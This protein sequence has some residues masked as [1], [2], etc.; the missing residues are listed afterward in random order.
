MNDAGKDLGKDL[1]SVRKHTMHDS[2][3]P[4]ELP[5]I[6]GY[7]FNSGVDFG[8]IVDSFATT[9]YQASELAKAIS[10]INAMRKD[11]C[12][13][14]LGYTS[15]MVSSGLREVFCYLAKH[16][17]VD[18][19]VTTAGGIEE[20]FIKCLGPFLLGE[21]NLPGKELREAGI[22]R[23]GNI[24]VPNSRYLAFEDF[25]IPVLEHL[26]EEQQKTG[27]V[28]T[29]SQFTACLG[30]EIRD[31][32]SIYFWAQ[33]NRIPVFCPA[34]TDGSIGD[35][36]YFFSFKHPGFKIDI[37]GDLKGLNDL[38]LEAKKT[39]LIILGAGVVKHHILNANM[40]RNGAD[41]AVYINTS[42]EFDGS[43][44]GAKP[45]E[46]VSWGKLLPEEGNENP[47]PTIQN[48]SYPSKTQIQ[49]SPKPPR[50]VKVF[51]DATILFPL[52]VAKTFAQRLNSATH[53]I[54]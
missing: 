1:T 21:F 15:N 5:S 32:N 20:D 10:I 27:A 52:I 42:Q 39:G 14:F 28:I 45:D 6:K 53:R 11:G 54:G 7:D 18:V 48:T 40:L 2:V 3:E 23:I 41:Y 31:E 26:Y 33:R 25:L 49:G 51:G 44:A 47:L 38:T 9:G 37:A 16:K 34:L 8:K 12:T 50:M 29:P 43:D 4:K 30:K 35:M 36:I 46:A 24:L 19:I 17:M 22:N 13:I